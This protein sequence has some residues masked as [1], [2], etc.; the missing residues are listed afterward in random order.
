MPLASPP[1]TAAAL[2]ALLFG[3]VAPSPGRRRVRDEGRNAVGGGPVEAAGTG[4]GARWGGGLNG[5]TLIVEPQH[6]LQ[7]HVIEQHVQR[8]SIRGTHLRCS[9]SAAVAASSL[10]YSIYQR[11]TLHHTRATRHSTATCARPRSEPSS[12]VSRRC[13]QVKTNGSSLQ[14]QQKHSSMHTHH[15]CYGATVNECIAKHV[16]GHNAG[17]CGQVGDEN[18]LAAAAAPSHISG[19]GIAAFYLHRPNGGRG[20]EEG[21]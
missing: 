16:A 12:R 2:P 15:V 10:S 18:G 6:T 13:S 20:V 1:A 8:L 4:A 9:C 11:I 3:C 21:E 14:T 5:S 7:P 17:V 19:G